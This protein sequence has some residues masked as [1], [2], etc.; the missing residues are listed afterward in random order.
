MQALAFITFVTYIGGYDYVYSVTKYK[1]VA[2]IEN[3]RHAALQSRIRIVVEG[4]QH[5]VN[6]I[7]TKL[8]ISRQKVS[9]LEH[10][11]DAPTKMLLYKPLTEFHNSYNFTKEDIA[12]LAKN[13]YYEAGVES[14]LGKYAVAQVTYNRT[15]HPNFPDSICK[16][17]NFKVTK[18]SKTTCAFSWVCMKKEAPKGRYWE[19]SLAIAN[20]FAKNNIRVYPVRKSLFYHAVYIK[21]PYWTKD[22]AMVSSVDQHIFY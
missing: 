22:M 2:K 4:I 5:D 19:R 1:P 12:C 18:N 17:V 6:I 21:K 8:N 3:I 15:L 14:D 13:I 11:L 20:D 9:D 7:Q 10:S 16:V